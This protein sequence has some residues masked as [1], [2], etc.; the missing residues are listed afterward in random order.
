MSDVLSTMSLGE[1]EGLVKAFGWDKESEMNRLPD[2]YGIK[3]IKF[4]WHG[5]WSDPEIEFRGKRCSCYIIEDTMWENWI[6]DDDGI[7]IPER[8]DDEDG[9]EQYMRD[10]AEEVKYLCTIV[11]F[12]EEVY[13]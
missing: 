2:W 9:F 11:L 12:P 5:E 8:E 1:L 13:G 4:I 3:G 7:L 10:N 6:H